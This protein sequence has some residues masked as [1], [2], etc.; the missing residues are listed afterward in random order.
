M[1]LFKSPDDAPRAGHQPGAAEGSHC[2]CTQVWP[3]SRGFS[4]TINFPNPAWPLN[5]PPRLSFSVLPLERQPGK[6]MDRRGTPPSLAL[7]PWHFLLFGSQPSHFDLVPFFTFI[8]ILIC[9]LP[10]ILASVPPFVYHFIFPLSPISLFCIPIPQYPLQYRY[11]FG[12]IYAKAPPTASSND[13]RPHA[14]NRAR[15]TACNAPRS[16]RICS[17]P[18]LHRKS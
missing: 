1:P 10:R 9:S 17:K 7:S 6:Q 18:G 13:N 14:F 2:T 5:K 8:A 11:L 4:A 12:S 3:I 15:P 16:C